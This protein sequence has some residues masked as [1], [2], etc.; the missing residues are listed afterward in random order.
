MSFADWKDR[1]AGFK[2]IDVR[3]VAGNFFPGL[4][5]QAMELPVGAG[6]EVVQTFEPRL[7]LAERSRGR[8]RTPSVRL[9]DHLPATRVDDLRADR[10]AFA[11]DLRR[12]LPPE[13]S[14]AGRLGTVFHDAVALRLAARGQL[15]TLAQAGVPDTLDPAGRCEKHL[16]HTD[17]LFAGTSP[18]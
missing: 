14:P 7:L 2:K 8:G 9:P 10:G 17:F 12:P 4:K 6:L 1:T 15:L 5:K 13:P 16:F 11:L 3:G 18:I